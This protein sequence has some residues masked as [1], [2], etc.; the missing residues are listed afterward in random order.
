MSLE[1]YPLYLSC[2][3]QFTS[4]TGDNAFKSDFVDAANC[5]FD[6]LSNYAKLTTALPHIEA[7]DDTV[8]DLDEN[9]STILLA[10]LTQYLI[11]RGRKHARGDQAYAVSDIQ[12]ADK[13]G[14][15]MQL[16]K[17]SDQATVDDDGVPTSDI[18]GLGYLEE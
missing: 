3:R 15:F 12:W 13:K 4:A 2:V 1:M 10:G 14:E 9:H 16:M 11:L 8:D 17:E 7:V 18:V 6:D 5:A